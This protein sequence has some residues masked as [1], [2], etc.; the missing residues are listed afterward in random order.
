MCSIW[1]SCFVL[2][3]TTFKKPPIYPIIPRLFVMLQPT[4]AHQPWSFALEVAHSILFR[5]S[6]V[7]A[8]CAAGQREAPDV[9]Q[10]DLVLSPP[11]LFCE[12]NVSL[13]FGV[14]RL[15]WREESLWD[16]KNL[17][18]S[19]PRPDLKC[20]FVSIRLCVWKPRHHGFPM[21]LQLFGSVFKW[22]LI[23]GGW[24]SWFSKGLNPST[25]FGLWVSDWLRWEVSKE[26][27]GWKGIR[28][29]SDSEPRTAWK[30]SCWD[31]FTQ[32][33]LVFW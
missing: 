7:D 18:A 14:P 25:V 13:K 8:S 10:R 26:L 31:L 29:P 5:V 11:H 32:V 20:T 22:C 33:I 3:S 9:Y 12:R 2:E 4:P 6:C 16:G 21:V 28:L 30:N 24:A 23:L 17:E 15:D 27:A 19:K 1:N